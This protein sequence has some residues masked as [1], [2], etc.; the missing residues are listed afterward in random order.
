MVVQIFSIKAV[1]HHENFDEQQLEQKR[2]EIQTAEKVEEKML[3]YG[4][5]FGVFDNSGRWLYGTFTESEREEVWEAVLEEKNEISSGYL[6]RFQREEGICLVS[7]QLRV[8]FGNPALRE[9]FPHV[10]ELLLLAALL[11]FC[12]EV[13]FLIRYFSRK[14]KQELQKIEWMTEKIEHQD[15]EFPCPD[16][17]V[18]EIKKILETFGRMRDTLKESLMKQWELESARKEQMGALAHD[19]KTP[20]TAIITYV[21]LL[22]DENLPAEERRH[23]IDVL[24]QKSTRLK[25]L[26]EDLF[27][28]S[29]A[30]SRNV[31]L[32]IMDVDIVSLM[33]QAKL[34]LH[35]KIEASNLYFRWRLPEDKVVLPLDSQKTYRVFENLLVNITKYAMPRTRVYV[36][37]END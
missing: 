34:E 26:I 22:K 35:D 32:N 4:T 6:K 31:T 10:L 28:I 14:I 37:M 7:Y 20:L 21:D 13:M 24:E 19:L 5:R 27:E 15:L 29:K 12:A 25:L 2:E 16:S 3:P 36:D 17:Q 30:T 33:Q 8:Q 1:I 23:Y 18:L 9:R 11:I